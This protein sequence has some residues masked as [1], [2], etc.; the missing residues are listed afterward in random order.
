M[1]DIDVQIYQPAKTATQSGLARTHHWALE[2]LP[3]RRSRIDPLTG[4]N[5]SRGSQRQIKLSFPDRES[6]IAFATRRGWTFIVR[7]SSKT[8]IRPKNYASNFLS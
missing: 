8:T 7:E 6:A 1:K 3:R 2:F 4:W 5:G